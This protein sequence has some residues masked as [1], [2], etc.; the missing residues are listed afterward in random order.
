MF[1]TD[2]AS[3]CKKHTILVYNQPILMFAYTRERERDRETETE[4]ERATH[5]PGVWRWPGR[6]SWVW[7]GGRRGGSWGRP[8]LQNTTAGGRETRPRIKQ[9]II[10]FNMHQH[11]NT[12]VSLR[13]SAYACRHRCK[14]TLVWNYRLSI[15]E[16]VNSEHPCNRVLNGVQHPRCYGMIHSALEHNNKRPRCLLL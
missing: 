15:I 10:M 9:I 8:A 12:A 14:G 6:C 2:E 3:K 11:P 1:R 13:A 4:R 16:G 7:P 5:P